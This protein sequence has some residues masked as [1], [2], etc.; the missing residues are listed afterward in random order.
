MEGSHDPAR[1]LFR[2]AAGVGSG[3]WEVSQG[4]HAMTI[5]NH[6]TLAAI[7]ATLTACTP[8]PAHADALLDPDSVPP[9]PARPGWRAP[10]ARPDQLP[11]GTAYDF[12]PGRGPLLDA[13]AEDAI[14]TVTPGTWGASTGPVS[15]PPPPVVVPRGCRP[16]AAVP[17]PAGLLGVGAM[18]TTARQLRRR[19]IR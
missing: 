19:I 11:A 10:A 6:I 12:D 4:A 15:L 18:F 1:L 8:I 2:A 5:R 14:W 13:H 3:G 9:D 7:L 16:P 17:G